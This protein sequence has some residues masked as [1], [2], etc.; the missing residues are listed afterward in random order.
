MGWLQVA[1][2]IRCSCLGHYCCCASVLSCCPAV[3]RNSRCDD[4]AEAGACPCKVLIGFPCRDS[5]LLHIMI[6]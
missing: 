4:Q 3:L 2:L 5:L 6:Q 1:D